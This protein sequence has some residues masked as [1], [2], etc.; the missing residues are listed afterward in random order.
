MRPWSLSGKIKTIAVSLIED[1]R[2]I[3]PWMNSGPLAGLG[4]IDAAAL[5]ATA[6]ES[7]M[8]AR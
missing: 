4:E 7:I 8:R 6:A 3:S 1:S 5:F 2:T